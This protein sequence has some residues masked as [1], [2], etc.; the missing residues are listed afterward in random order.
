MDEKEQIL[1]E[2][3]TKKKKEIERLNLRQ[4]IFTEIISHLRTR[5]SKAET[6]KREIH[7]EIIDLKDKVYAWLQTNKE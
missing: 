1:N 7:N 2:I 3:E 5:V 6:R 4:Q